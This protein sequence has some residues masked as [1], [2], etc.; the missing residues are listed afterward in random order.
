MSPTQTAGAVETVSLSRAQ[1]DRW[2]EMLATWPLPVAEL[3]VTYAI[4]GPLDVP[5]FRDALRSVVADHEQLR[6]RVAPSGDGYV[7]TVRPRGVA[8]PVALIDLSG[9]DPDAQR[10][11]RDVYAAREAAVPIDLERS[12]PVRAILLLL[13]P[14]RFELLLTVSHIVADGWCLGI[15]VG[16]LRARYLAVDRG[17]GEPPPAP[18][19]YR[20]FVEEDEAR[21]DSGAHHRHVA[22][23]RQQLRGAAARLDLGD[24]P[25]DAL[26]GP[27]AISQRFELFAQLGE[28]ALAGARSLRVTHM[29]IGL[30]VLAVQ[31]L[32]RSGERV[33]VIV[34][35]FVGPRFPRYAETIGLFTNRLVV[36]LDLTA[37][38]SFGDVVRVVREALI[39]AFDRADTPGHLVTEDLHE[40]GRELSLQVTFQVFPA[41]LTERDRQDGLSISLTDFRSAARSFD[42]QLL[43]TEPGEQGI[44]G[45]LIHRT[46]VLS[47]RDG[48]LWIE[49]YGAI[50]EQA[51]ADPDGPLT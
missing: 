44:T 3:S 35:P 20:Q 14:E 42:L 11:L 13:A 15:L 50:L 12:L 7:A 29:M 34:V 4:D 47:P 17:P 37:A 31:L 9:S 6:L 33:F 38:S 39:D 30:A 27:D 28:A 2:R 45:W 22:W 16:E 18:A 48:R 25:A 40:Q 32:K 43:L 5:A 26:A 19:P 21:Y 41:D 8:V 1:E 10:R 23:W 36:R 51:L 49:E 46:S 24:A